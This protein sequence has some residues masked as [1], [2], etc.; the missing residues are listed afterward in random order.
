MND[1]QKASRFAAARLERMRAGIRL[2]ADTAAEVRAA[3][4]KAQADIAAILSGAPTDYKAWQLGQLQHSVKLALAE[5]N[6]S[7]NGTLQRGLGSSWQAGQSLI[8]APLSAAG[9]DIAADLVAIDTR[10]LMAM[11]RFTTERISDVSVKLAN[12]INSELAQAA[13]GVQSPFEA[14]QVIAGKLQTGGLDRANVIVRHQLGTAFSTAAQERQEQAAVIM[15]GLK[16]QWRRSGKT[17]SRIEHDLIDGQ[18]RDVD[19]PFDL[20]NGVQL[21]HPRDPEGPIGETIN[22]GCTSLPWVES[23]EVMRPGRQAFSKE[24]LDANRAKRMVADAF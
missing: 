13:I 12:A 10:R 18:V 24:E 1:R 22:C 8:D 16:K 20:P 15:P 21:M 17:H 11:R 23:W 19:K 7:A 9:V 6:A 14:A 3:L 4:I 5:L 2:Q